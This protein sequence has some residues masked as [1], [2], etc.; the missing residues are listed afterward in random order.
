MENRTHM[1]Y[2]IK[3]K[4]N[5]F[6][7]KLKA[8][9]S[10]T[11]TADGPFPYEK[12]TVAYA[13]CRYIRHCPELR[14]PLIREAVKLGLTVRG[15][16][17]H[18]RHR[19]R[20]KASLLSL[21]GGNARITLLIRQGEIIVKELSIEAEKDGWSNIDLQLAHDFS[22]NH[23]PELEKDRVCGCFYCGNI[24]SPKEILNWVI[25]DTPIDYRGTALCPY[26]MIDSVIGESSGYPIAPK[27]LRA[28]NE[29]WF[30]FEPFDSTRKSRC[31]KSPQNKKAQH[32]SLL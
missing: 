15:K 31:S 9:N 25:A 22:S 21:P 7:S 32:D 29:R 13:V 4:D 6:G 19:I 17:E 16:R 5:G 10:F 27:F 12:D 30:S 24:F 1:T 2:T 28:M 3:T 18:R 8:D 20:T 11:F 26:C 23:K 14:D